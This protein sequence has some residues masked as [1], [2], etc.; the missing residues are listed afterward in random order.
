MGIG[1]LGRGTLVNP[2]PVGQV[3][4]G[5]RRGNIVCSYACHGGDCGMVWQIRDL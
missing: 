3:P 1:G 4:G 5:L 2:E